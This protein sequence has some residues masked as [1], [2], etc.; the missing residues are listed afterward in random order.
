MC[1]GSVYV[2]VQEYLIMCPA[3]SMHVSWSIY[4][5]V[6]E[7]LCTCP[8]VSMYVSWSIP[9]VSVCHGSEISTKTRAMFSRAMGILGPGLGLF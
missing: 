3:V 4:V 2:C 6:L 9:N 7:C 1:P 8:G 5:S